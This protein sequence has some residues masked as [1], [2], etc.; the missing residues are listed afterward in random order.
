MTLAGEELPLISPRPNQRVEKEIN[1]NNLWRRATLNTG[2]LGRGLLRLQGK[3]E[4][5]FSR[6]T[7]E[8]ALQSTKS[9]FRTDSQAVRIH[10]KMSKTLSPF[11]LLLTYILRRRIYCWVF[12]ISCSKTNQNRVAAVSSRSVDI[13]ISV[14]VVLNIVRR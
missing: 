7:W 10:S 9:S 12:G 8:R 11:T 6:N 14:R 3:G 13:S 2:L 5:N 4:P 1:K